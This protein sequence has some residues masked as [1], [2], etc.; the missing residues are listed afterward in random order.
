[1]TVMV[2]RDLQR[3]N[4]V[5]SQVRPSEITDRRIM[6]AMQSVE[7]DKFLPETLQDLAYFDGPLALPSRPGAPTRSELAPRVLAKM[8]Q[9]AE[10][11]ETDVILDVGAGTGWSS[12]L[13]GQMGETVVA[14][15]VDDG[16]A[17]RATQTL[18]ELS[19]DN[20]AVVEGPLEAG[21]AQAGPYDVIVIEGGLAEDPQALFN[22]LKSGGRLVAILHDKGIGKVC[23]WK[24]SG[25]VVSK[26]VCFDAAAP[27]LPGFEAVPAFSL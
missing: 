25:D 19:I 16:L 2:D 10:I 4:M 12:A 1:M 13:L 23:C 9:A 15:E 11:A 26:R 8:I 14:L 20:V 18:S 7:R 24:R 6:R 21:Y 3:R 27:T 5:E 17:K 22:Q